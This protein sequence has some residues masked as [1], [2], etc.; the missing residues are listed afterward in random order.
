[1]K[2]DLNSLEYNLKN[3]IDILGVKRMLE[4]LFSNLDQK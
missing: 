4:Y 1:M 2:L 3:L